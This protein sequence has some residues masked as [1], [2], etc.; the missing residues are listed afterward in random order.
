MRR[1]GGFLLLAIFLICLIKWKNA[2]PT[3]GQR[4]ESHFPVLPMRQRLRI[5]EQAAPDVRKYLPIPFDEEFD[6]PCFRNDSRLLCLPAFFVAGGMQCGVPDMWSRLTAH[7]HV[8]DHHDAAPHWWTNHPRSTAG[9]FDRYLSLFSNAK[10]V[11]QI[12]AEP[13]TLLGDVSPASLAF[14]MAEQ[15]RLHYQFLDAFDACYRQCRGHSPPAQLAARCKSR[16]YHMD[17]CYGE[18]TSATAPLAFNVPALMATVLHGAAPKVVVLLREPAVR[19]W[20]AFHFYGQYPARYGK[21]AR[22]WEF[23]FGNQS[24]AWAACADVHGSHACALRFEGHSHVQADVYYHCDQLIKGMYSEFVPEWQAYVR[25]QRL[26]V[27]RSE[28]YFERPLRS[29]RRVWRLLGLRAPTDA[30]RV[31]AERPT[32]RDEAQ[33]VRDEHGEPPAAALAAVRRFYRPFNARLAE[34]L[35][36]PAFTWEDRQPPQVETTVGSPPSLRA[37]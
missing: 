32:P 36:D 8:G 33:Q 7:A 37:R 9:F 35:D 18:A 34:Q 30:E 13:R 31:A 1:S 11:A 19:L 22:G 14:V 29:V 15:L 23:Y 24:A 27:L 3:S 2:R 20:V 21:H 16:E 26:L 17:H 10:T 4:P 25:P 12:Q 6:N 28:D 5:V